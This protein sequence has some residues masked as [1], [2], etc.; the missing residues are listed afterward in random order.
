MGF[1]EGAG[2]IWSSTPNS[3]LALGS[4]LPARLSNRVQQEMEGCCLSA[5]ELA[6]P[7]GGG[8]LA[9]HPPQAAWR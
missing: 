2:A 9:S 7:T 6:P 1:L 5:P 3:P 8:C 4:H